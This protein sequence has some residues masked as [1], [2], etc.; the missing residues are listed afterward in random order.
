MCLGLLLRLRLFS[1]RLEL[2]K[3]QRLTH[4]IAI[5]LMIA[6]PLYHVINR[7][8]FG[9]TT[10]VHM[11]AACIVDTQV[12]NLDVVSTYLSYDAMASGGLRTLRLGA[13]ER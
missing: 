11:R 8:R 12:K 9:V 7:R 2:V 10:V 6:F 5:R 4:H 1:E 13:G 3:A